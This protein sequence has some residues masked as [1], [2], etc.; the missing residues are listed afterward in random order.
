MTVQPMILRDP[1]QINQVFT[2]LPAGTNGLLFKNSV[3]N[4]MTQTLRSFLS[5]L[6]LGLECL[7]SIRSTMQGLPRASVTLDLA[8]RARAL[9]LSTHIASYAHG[10]IL[11]QAD[12]LSQRQ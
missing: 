11:H 1:D 5:S 8:Q 7:Q 12:D 9:A 10:K 2:N 6:V 4:L 3:I